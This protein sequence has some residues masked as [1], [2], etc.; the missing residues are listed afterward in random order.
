MNLNNE[1][2]HTINNPYLIGAAGRKEWNDRYMVMSDAIKNWQ[3]VAFISLILVV[4]F[5]VLVIKLA[6][7]TKIQPFV[8][9][10]HDGVPYVM[11]P[12][13]AISDQDQRLIS[14]ALNQFII[15]SRS[16]LGDFDAEK[17]T[18]NKVYAFSSGSTL[19]FLHDF[20]QKRDPFLQAEKET[21][22]VNIINTLPVSKNTWQITWDEV[23]HSCDSG[24]LIE[25]SR[26]IAQ[27]T[28]QLGEVN[29]KFINENPFGIYI[30]RI[31]WSQSKL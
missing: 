14:F 13:K 30:S 18:L 20:Y 26:W 25:T 29:P 8:V 2:P 11:K 4:L 12:M 5:S 24:Q 21:V 27:L 10:T 23:K 7:S 19:Q 9:E 15:N 31:T 22:S 17:T 3:R 28:Y 16:I 6:L 1:S